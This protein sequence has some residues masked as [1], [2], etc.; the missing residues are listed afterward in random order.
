M[1]CPIRHRIRQLVR[2]LWPQESTN[3][4]LSEDG[5]EETPSAASRG[6]SSDNQQGAD[7]VKGRGFDEHGD[8]GRV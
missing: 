4:S 1:P 3:P 8:D 6:Q 5:Q 7:G 2:R